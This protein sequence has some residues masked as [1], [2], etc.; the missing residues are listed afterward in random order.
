MGVSNRTRYKVYEV[1]DVTYKDGSK[2]KLKLMR[3][4]FIDY[5]QAYPPYKISQQKLGSI[6]KLSSFS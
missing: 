1:V 4:P 3:Q 2:G 5:G 6:K